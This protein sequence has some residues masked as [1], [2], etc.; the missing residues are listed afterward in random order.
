[1][2]G[3]GVRPQHHQRA[4]SSRPRAP[5]PPPS[6][7]RLPRHPRNPPLRR[8]PAQPL[9]Q[10][11]QYAHRGQGVDQPRRPRPRDP[12]QPHRQPPHRIVGGRA[13]APGVVV[14][15]ELRLVR[16]HVDADRAVRAAALAGQ[17][18]VESVADLRGAPAVGH[19]LA[20][21]HLVQQARAPARGVLLLARRAE[22]GAHD[23]GAGRRCRTAF[24]YAY[25]AADGRG[26]VAAVRGVTE[27]HVDRFPGEDRE[28]EVRVEGGRA[29]QHARVQQV[30]RVP[31][32]LGPLEQAHQL[33][34]V[35]PREQLRPRL[36]VP[37]FSGERAAV[38]HHQIR[39]LLGEAAEAA[40][41]RRREQIEVDPDV[42]AAVPEVAVRRAAQA[43]CGQQ[44][45]EV[46]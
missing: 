41:A 25:A 38:G 19:H 1:M 40:D 11:R 20:R 16:G 39:Q 5:T 18:Q 21:E 35:H 33:R 43:V 23:G 32:R 30:V 12:P 27:G 34:A 13:A 4:V 14:V 45:A 7:E 9:A 26:E 28:A 24:G 46:P 42:D 17:A 31:Y 8:D 22:G 44:G 37:V 36:S 3:E 10:G 29:D 15:Q 2:L 6:A